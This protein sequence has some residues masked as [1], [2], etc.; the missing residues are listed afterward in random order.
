MGETFSPRAIRAAAVSTT[1]L[2]AVAGT[3][4]LN[5]LIS[6]NLRKQKN[7]AAMKATEAN[8]GVNVRILPHV[9]DS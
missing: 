7:D 1:I 5:A 3:A 9:R 4:K 6:N 2:P 8:T